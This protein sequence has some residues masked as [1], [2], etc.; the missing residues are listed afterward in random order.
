MNKQ[1]N[2]T[3]RKTGIYKIT[4]PSGKI[5]IGQSIDIEKRWAYYK[6]KKTNVQ[7]KLQNSF[8]KHGV[9]SHLF[10]IL[11]L[12]LEGMLNQRERHW[13]DFYNVLTEGLNLK[14]T[15][16]DEMGRLSPATLEK[17]QATRKQNGGYISVQQRQLENNTAKRPEVKMKISEKIK[18]LWQD[19]AYRANRKP[20][21]RVVCPNCGLESNINIMK[22]WH[23][24]NCTKEK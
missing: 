15:P 19:P 13:Q 8:N 12:C 3:G 21:P 23:F 24:E 2:D 1:S 6:T 11:E 9:E 4:S 22:R 14:L 20:I 17:R 5:Y 18:S 7:P 10:E 16:A